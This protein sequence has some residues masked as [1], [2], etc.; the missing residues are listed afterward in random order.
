MKHDIYGDE[1]IRSTNNKS[2]GSKA[3]TPPILRFG[4]GAWGGNWFLRW[5]LSSFHWFSDRNYFLSENQ[6]L[7]ARSAGPRTRISS[8]NTRVRVAFLCENQWN[9]P[10][11]SNFRAG[12]RVLD[13]QRSKKNSVTQHGVLQDAYAYM[14]TW[15]T[16][17][18]HREVYH[19]SHVSPRHGLCMSILM[20]APK[21]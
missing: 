10:C 3:Q 21:H 4:Q 20:G 2:K 1:R 12:A 5:K 11:Q 13:I 16:A 15:W 18:I 14:S 7:R 8:T 6:G 19:F 17:Q 9:E